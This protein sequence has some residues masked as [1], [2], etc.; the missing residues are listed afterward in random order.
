MPIADPDIKN[1]RRIVPEVA[2]IVRRIAMSRVL[3]F[4]IMIM[5]EMMLNAGDDDDQRQD[6]E[7]HRALDLKRA[8]EGRVHL[9]PI[10][11]ARRRAATAASILARISSTWSGFSTMTSMPVTPVP[12]LK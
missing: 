8:E 1:T 12:L 5:P 4:T 6:Q 2:P 9:A 7:H 10:D 3:S 11:H